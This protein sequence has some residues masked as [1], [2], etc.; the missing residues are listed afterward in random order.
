MTKPILEIQQE[1]DQAGELQILAML[2][3]VVKW[4][5]NYNVPYD[6]QRRDQAQELLDQVLAAGEGERLGALSR[7]RHFL[8]QLAEQAAA[9]DGF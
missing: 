3:R 1:V 8:H 7:A 5:V 6:M 9:L 4:A 2:G